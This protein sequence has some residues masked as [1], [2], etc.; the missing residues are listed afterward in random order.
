VTG[1]QSS[2]RK[3]QAGR[4][5]VERAAQLFQGV[6]CDRDPLRRTRPQLP[7]RGRDRRHRAVLV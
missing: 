3:V 6:V 1:T 4:N 2:T 5:V 7:R